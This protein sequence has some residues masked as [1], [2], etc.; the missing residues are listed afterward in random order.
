MS[1][2]L[3]AICNRAEF[4]NFLK[5]TKYFLHNDVVDF[6]FQLLNFTLQRKNVGVEDRFPQRPH[7]L[8][9]LQVLLLLG[10]PDPHGLGKLLHRCIQHLLM[11]AG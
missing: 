5:R 10:H 7:F 9:L 8:P 11:D 2:W 1:L 6:L 3:K 4:Y